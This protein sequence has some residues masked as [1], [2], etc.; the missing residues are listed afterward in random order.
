MELLKRKTGY[1]YL[2]EEEV[3]LEEEKNAKNRLKPLVLRLNIAFQESF[4]QRQ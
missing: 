3:D 1:G 2:E 4:V